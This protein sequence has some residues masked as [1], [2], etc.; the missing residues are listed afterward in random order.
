[1]ML[2]AVQSPKASAVEVLTHVDAFLESFGQTLS[3]F[4]AERLGQQAAAL[5]RLQLDSEPA[6]SMERT[7]QNHLAGL[8]A[9]HPRNVAEA[10]RKLQLS[11]LIQQLQAL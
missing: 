7:W 2:F 5:S 9:D 6:A 4:T 11:D 1:G 10:L 3:A 8:P